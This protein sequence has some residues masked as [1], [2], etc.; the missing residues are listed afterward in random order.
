M[1]AA[2]IIG[3]GDANR[4]ECAASAVEA[5]PRNRI[6]QI[7]HRLATVL[8]LF[9]LLGACS[10][11]P[12]APA[13]TPS[14]AES[15]APKPAVAAASIGIGDVDSSMQILLRVSERSR[16][17]TIL[18]QERMTMTN[19]LTNVAVSVLPPF[20]GELWLSA[21]IKSLIGFPGH[22]VLVSV[23]IFV[24]EKQVDTFSYVVG[25]DAH[26]NPK[27]H[28]FDALQGLASPPKSMLVRAT[29]DVTLYANTA[30]ADLDVNNPPPAGLEAKATILSN[31]VRIEF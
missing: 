15:E 1:G 9:V 3:G 31:P 29:A 21:T 22:A 8:S 28:E 20:P 12:A 17:A 2:D 6:V 5:F 23:N 24:D 16:S 30:P 7:M 11:G 4:V 26:T 18:E 27:A 14:A 19:K 10:K 13:A 25:E